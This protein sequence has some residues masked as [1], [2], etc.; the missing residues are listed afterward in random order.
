M[1][2]I[3][4]TLITDK[5][6][7]NG[8]RPAMRCDDRPDIADPYFAVDVGET[9]TD[10]VLQVFCLIQTVG[11]GNEAFSAVIRTAR[12]MDFHGFQ[13]AGNGVLLASHLIIGNDASLI[14]Q[15]HQRANVQHSAKHRSRPRNTAALPQ[16]F[17]ICGE[18]L[19][20]NGL[21]VLFY[22]LFNFNERFPL[23]T[24]IRSHIYQ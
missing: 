3:R 8:S 24:H 9:I 19:V 15:M 14:V 5:E 1:R 23:I 2:R 22:P 7:G 16:V 11:M 6:N 13:Y 10:Q 18:K 12:R 4:L 17:Q 20:V 21:A